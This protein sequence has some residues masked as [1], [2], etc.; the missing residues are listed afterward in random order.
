MQ[1]TSWTVFSWSGVL[2]RVIEK[3]P[4][5]K[6]CTVI[7]HFL[8]GVLVHT[9]SPKQSCCVQYDLNLLSTPKLSLLYI[10]V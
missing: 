2:K 1:M 7:D 3:D 5:A 8:S 4:F 9:D 10:S 6:L